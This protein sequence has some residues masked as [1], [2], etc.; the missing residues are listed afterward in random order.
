MDKN[1]TIAYCSNLFRLKPNKQHWYIHDWLTKV[2]QFADVKQFRTII[3]HGACFNQFG[4]IVHSDKI[5]QMYNAIC[6]LGTFIDSHE[7]FR[8]HKNIVNNRNDVTAQELSY[9]VPGELVYIV[10]FEKV[11]QDTMI[12]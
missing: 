8:V 2:S 1:I 7:C 3:D 11:L 5:E 6:E 10:A 4:I 9:N 12:E